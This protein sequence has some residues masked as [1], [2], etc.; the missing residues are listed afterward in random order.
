MLKRAAA[1]AAAAVLCV[2][3]AG[4]AE[5][6]RPD[7]GEAVMR[8]LVL[9]FPRLVR[10]PEF[11]NGDWTVSLR[12]ETFFYAG[13]KLLPE[14]LLREA[15]DYSP[16]PF[17]KYSPALPEWEK[18]SA[19][20]VKI[21]KAGEAARVKGGDAKRSNFFF[22]ALWNVRNR[23]E[24]WKQVKTMKFLRRE[25]LVHHAVLEPLAMVEQ[26][27]NEQAARDEEVAGWVKNIGDIHG[28]NWR[29]IAGGGARSNHS[30]GTAL[31]ILPKKL[32]NR[33]TYWLWTKNNNREWWNV[34][35]SRRYS[36][37]AGVIKAFEDYGFVWGGKWVFFDTMHFEYRPELLIYNR[38]E[39][40]GEF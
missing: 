22:D 20:E 23:N 40:S 17:Y 16:Y 32:K 5:A 27:I 21:I 30:Y 13:G 6:V 12:G 4:A 26:R 7:D 28:W 37:P 31:D 2:F 3:G 25:I 8:S 38:M 9:A 14:R 10:G 15:G 18:P 35:Y 39:P 19:E 29:N 34:P 1:V 24:A 33:D 36:P 11:R